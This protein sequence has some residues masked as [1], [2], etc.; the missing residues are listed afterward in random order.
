MTNAAFA[1]FKSRMLIKVRLTDGELDMVCASFVPKNV[2]RRQY[3]LQSEGTCRSIAF[4]SKG[5]LRLYWVDEKGEE[6]VVQLAIEGVVDLG[7]AKLSLRRAG[8]AQHRRDRRCRGSAAGPGDAGI[9]LPKNS[10]SRTLLPDSRG[11]VVRSRPRK[12]LGAI[13]RLRR[14]ALPPLPEI[15]SR[16]RGTRSQG[17]DRLLPRHHPAF[18]QAHPQGARRKIVILRLSQ[19]KGVVSPPP[20][21][22]AHR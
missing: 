2:R 11:R 21:E 16:I 8:H 6:S 4:V 20:M 17:A 13:M 22:L 18:S 9:R 15:L 5:C 14:G 19:A 3:L 1:P 7:H 12:Y 10:V